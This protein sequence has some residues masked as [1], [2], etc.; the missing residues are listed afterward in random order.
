MATFGQIA[1]AVAFKKF[2]ADWTHTRSRP[3]ID[4]SFEICLANAPLGAV[5]AIRAGSAVWN[6]RKFKFS[7]K[8]E[9]CGSSA[10][11]PVKNDVNQIDFGPVDND[12]P[13]E[14]KV[15]YDGES[16]TECD[17]RFNSALNWNVSDK[18]PLYNQW[19]LIS[20]AA[21]EFGHCLGLADEN[22]PFLKNEPIM[23]GMLGIGQIRRTL[24]TNDRNGRNSIYG[25]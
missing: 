18:S 22:K 20:V 21:H 23:N 2:G 6:Y 10:A 3:R 25:K 13:G 7:F 17:I 14:S 11:F 19:D 5:S 9:G 15:Y 1:E 8:A 24:S 12:I 16:I 4:G